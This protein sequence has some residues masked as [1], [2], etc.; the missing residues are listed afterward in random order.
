MPPLDPAT[1][2]RHEAALG[3]IIEIASD[4]I[5]S[6]DESFRIVLFNRG[7]E[8]IFGRTAAETVGRS[9]DILLPD[10]Y[11][12]VHR[13]HVR[14]FAHSAVAARRMGERGEITGL[15]AS[16][17]E[18]PAE[19]SISRVTLDDETIFAVVLRDVTERHRIERA[20]RFIALAGQRLSAS[21][22]MRTTLDVV[23][24]LAVG[25]LCDCCVVYDAAQP[26]AI[27]QIALRCR[28]RRYRPLLDSLSGETLDPRVPHPAIAVVETGVAELIPE[29]T[30]GFLEEHAAASAM[31]LFRELEVKS[32]ILAPLIAR[33]RTLGVLGLYS[34]QPGRH[35]GT[36][37]LGVAEELAN[38]AAFAIDNAA[39]YQEARHA[40]QARD[41]VLAVVSHDL[42]NP[43]SAIRIGTSLLLRNVPE[44]E[45]GKGGW[46]HLDQ[47][48]ESAGQME[49]LVNDLL[50]IKRIEA[51]HLTLRRERV[52]ATRLLQES[53]EMFQ[54][55]ADEKG[56]TLEIRDASEERAVRGDRERLL[57]VFSNLI[58]NALKFTAAGGRVD[59]S[60]EA[61][62]SHVRF[63][64]RDTGRG[65]EADHLP[66]VFDRFWKAQRERREGIGLG[67]AIAQGIVRAHDGRIWADSVEGKGS[68]F[69]F[70]LPVAEPEDFAI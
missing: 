68:S 21:L 33:D 65:I 47:I 44:E 9:L 46:A 13:D 4:A 27:R 36:Y 58:G 48:R 29:I 3:A 63:I 61:A 51:G 62:G 23:T 28:D 57:Q 31:R 18:F 40:V 25:H 60:A 24:E 15:R 8:M 38:R 12:S 39:L 11:R 30:P 22:D 19:A 6:V 52:P 41:D 37:D 66:H 26:G 43:L 20:Q 10:Q 2:R 67:L 49:R 50:D 53:V 56:I 16:G 34:T 70:T 35:Y 14:R 64:V 32:A 5:I 1:R 42:G 55:L 17:E 45:R 54:G 69:G 7:A 59:V